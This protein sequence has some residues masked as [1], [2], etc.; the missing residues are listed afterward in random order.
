[1]R[2]WAKERQRAV[3]QPYI[4]VMQLEAMAF[5]FA[6]TA[7]A[8]PAEMA[9]FVPLALLAACLGFMVFR[10]MSGEQFRV[11]VNVLLASSGAA[12]LAG[13]L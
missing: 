9:L 8:V 11:L 3:Y 4:L 7:R 1:M 2:G 6:G 10:R 12:L 13:A 5:L